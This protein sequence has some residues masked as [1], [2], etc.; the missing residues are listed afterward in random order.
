MNR[1]STTQSKR[2]AGLTLTEVLVAIAIIAILAALLYPVLSGAKE[3]ARASDC[4]SN[5]RQLGTAIQLYHQ[6]YDGIYPYAIDPADKYCRQIWDRYPEWKEKIDSMPFLHEM[7][8]TYIRSE[9]IWRCRSDI[10]YDVLDIAGIP[11]DANPSSY[12]KFGTSYFYRTELTFRR[13]MQERIQ[14]PSRVNMLMDAAGRWH[15]DRHDITGY[16]YNVVFCDYHAKSL[17][18]DQYMEAW[19]EEL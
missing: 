1:R 11:L 2:R 17:S 4:M 16:R 8:Q 9:E 5:I 13:M 6:D 15:G 10:G 3:R 19:D 12:E 7:M 14:H 18:R